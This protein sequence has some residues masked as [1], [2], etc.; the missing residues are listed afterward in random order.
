M[1]LSMTPDANRNA[2][3]LNTRAAFKGMLKAPP[4]VVMGMTLRC[5]HE[6]TRSRMPSSSVKHADTVATRHIS[7]TGFSVRR[8]VARVEYV[9]LEIVT[10]TAETNFNPIIETLYDYTA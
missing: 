4:S 9:R 8:A 7:L 10:V 2:E 3:L 6:Q 1:T 5:L